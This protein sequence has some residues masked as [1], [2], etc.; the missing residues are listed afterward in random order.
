MQQ[1]IV[2]LSLYDWVFHMDQMAPNSAVILTSADW[3]AAL[4]AGG[5][6]MPH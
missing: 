3:Q 4:V 2:A 6:T 5:N 1:V